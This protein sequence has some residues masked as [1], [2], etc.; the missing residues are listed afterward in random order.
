VAARR[1]QRDKAQT[2]ERVVCE[3]GV[4]CCEACIRPLQLEM[5]VSADVERRD[6]VATGHILFDH[7]CPCEPAT[8]RSSRAF[9][10]YPSFL[11]LFGAQP[12]L[13]YYAPFAW[14][15]MVEDDPTLA[16]WRWEVGQVADWDEFMLFLGG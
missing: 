5:V 13:P 7:Y 9:G 12:P 15:P 11:A 4:Y 14:R 1:L 10:S 2:P 16:R 3:L 8:V 6:G